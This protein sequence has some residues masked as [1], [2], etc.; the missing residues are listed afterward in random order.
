VRTGA[1][2]G[3]RLW[4]GLPLLVILLWSVGVLTAVTLPGL[5]VPPAVTEVGLPLTRFARDVS[6]MITVGT[7]VVGGLLVD[8]REPQLMK[9]AAGWAC[10]WLVSLAALFVLTLSDI[11]AVSPLE[12]LDPAAITEFL[13]HEAIGHVFAV[14]AALVIVVLI[15]CLARAGRAVRW[16]SAGLAV[17]ASA[18]PA[19]LGH[20]DSTHSHAAATISLGIHIAAVSV[21]VGGLAAL[22]GLVLVSPEAGRRAVPRFSL[23]ALV[24]VV[25]VAESGL[26]NASLRVGAPSAFVSTPYG[27]LVIGKAVLLGALVWG[28]WVQRRKVVSPTQTD[29]T[30]RSLVHLA[31]VE[32]LAMGWAIAVSV[33]LARVG[34]GPALGGHPDA[35]LPLAVVLLALA[36][37]LLVAWAAPPS[38]DRR[39]VRRV[40]SVPEV[41]AIVLLIVVVEVSGVGVLRLVLGVE[42]SAI[43]GSVLLVASG[44]LWA[45]AASDRRGRASVVLL[46]VGWP[47]A[48]WLSILL[49]ANGHVTR[50]DVASLVL[51]EALLG[52]FLWRLREP[53][54]SP[55]DQPI[56]VGG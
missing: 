49:S 55:A 2:L 11:Q 13:A 9:W 50:L 18:A 32:F 38:A 4:W 5:P 29:A 23:L 35:F 31:G 28:G 30:T 48:L 26:L 27:A 47:F 19:F 36:A 34:P 20:S 33:T 21:W 42:G 15:V 10:A 39:W 17:C 56:P 45:V 25:V 41:V 53:A 8:R 6:A 12:T 24:C 14:Q 44:W 16:I 52:G 51:A 22:V 7:L 37:G 40:R 1:A 3:A 54:V 46:M 43:A